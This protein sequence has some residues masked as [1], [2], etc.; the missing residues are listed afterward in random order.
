M[1]E[2]FIRSALGATIMLSSLWI[3]MYA[4]ADNPARGLRDFFTWLSDKRKTAPALVAIEAIASVGGAL[5]VLYL[6]PPSSQI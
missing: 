5:L 6:F 2:V 3:G 1:F 4:R